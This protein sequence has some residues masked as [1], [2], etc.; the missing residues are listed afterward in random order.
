MLTK[1]AAELI[2]RSNNFGKPEVNDELMLLVRIDSSQTEVT[3]VRFTRPSA[4]DSLSTQRRNLACVTFAA[5]IPAGNVARLNLM[6]ARQIWL[7][8]FVTRRLAFE[9][10]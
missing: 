2:G 9:P 6:K 4:L 5:V 3:G 1:S 8:L 7:P 10:C